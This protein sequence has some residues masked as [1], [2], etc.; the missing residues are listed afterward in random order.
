MN[1]LPASPFEGM[2]QH[3]GGAASTSSGAGPFAQPRGMG[4]TQSMDTTSN[5]ASQLGTERVPVSRAVGS[6]AS[7]RQEPSPRSR[8][9]PFEAYKQQQQLQQQVSPPHM[10]CL[11]VLRHLLA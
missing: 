3:S 4:Q 5:S 8:E 11:H 10:T 1:Q 9:S 7:G 2:R 6:S